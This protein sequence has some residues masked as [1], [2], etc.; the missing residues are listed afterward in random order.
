MLNFSFIFTGQIKEWYQSSKVISLAT[1]SL[2]YSNWWLYFFL[3][4]TLYFQVNV[5]FYDNWQGSCYIMKCLCYFVHP[6]QVALDSPLEACSV[7]LKHYEPYLRDPVGFPRVMV[8]A[9]S[10][11]LSVS[12]LSLSVSTG[13]SWQLLSNLLQISSRIMDLCME[14][15]ESRQ[16][17]LPLSLSSQLITVIFH[18]YSTGWEAS[19]SLCLSTFA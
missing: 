8:G 18:H 17:A 5:E 14:I 3:S 19:T 7:Y 4:S 11:S 2:F 1:W 13:S 10:L 15:P 9:L 12:T 6:L 16:E